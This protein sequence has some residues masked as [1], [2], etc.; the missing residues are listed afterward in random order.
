MGTKSSGTLTSDV[1]QKGYILLERGGGI[2]MEDW[3]RQFAENV[4]DAAAEEGM[5]RF[6]KE[7]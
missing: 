5:A 6:G 2:K 1:A 7:E 3:N 4:W